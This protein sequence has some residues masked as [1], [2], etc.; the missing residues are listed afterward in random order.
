M[1]LLFKTLRK[2]FFNT[3]MCV[4]EIILSSEIVDHSM[5]FFYFV[6]V[7]QESQMV[8]GVMLTGLAVLVH[9]HLYAWTLVNWTI[10]IFWMNGCAFWWVLEAQKVSAYP[11]FTQSLRIKWI[12]L[13]IVTKINKKQRDF[14]FV[15]NIKCCLWGTTCST[16]RSF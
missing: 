2:S 1:N 16:R 9:C 4:K 3:K 14:E 12:P 15:N 5:S 7:T 6:T 13:R 8:F 10:F 11:D